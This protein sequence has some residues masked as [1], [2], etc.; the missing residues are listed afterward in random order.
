MKRF[1]QEKAKILYD[2]WW[3]FEWINII[4]FYDSGNNGMAKFRY[5]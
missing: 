4:Y 5:T 3:T 2:N 1:L